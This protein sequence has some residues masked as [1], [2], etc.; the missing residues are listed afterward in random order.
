MQNQINKVIRCT[1]EYKLTSMIQLFI[2]LISPSDSRFIL[3]DS[4]RPI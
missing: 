3:I 2:S 1:S 4:Y